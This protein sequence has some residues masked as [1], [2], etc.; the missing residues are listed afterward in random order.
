MSGFHPKKTYRL[1]SERIR[2]AV[3]FYLIP[4]KCYLS[5]KYKQIF[6]RPIDWKNP[7][8]FSEKLNWLKIY[9]RKPI[10]HLLVDKFRAKQIVADIIGEE[11]IIPTI[12]GPFQNVSE[13]DK[14]KLPERFVI[15]CNHDAASLMICEDK[16]KFDWKFADYKLTNCMNIDFYKSDCRQ[17]TYKGIERCIFV[18]QFIEDDKFDCLAD[19]KFYC[20]NG[21][22]KAIYVTINRFTKMS[23]SMYDMDWNLMPFEHIHP[24]RGDKVP[25]PKN[26]QLMKELAE[27][28]AK[29]V[30]NPYVRVDFYETNGRVYFGEITF[31]PESGMCYFKPEEWDYTMGSWMDISA[32]QKK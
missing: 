18:E 14:D 17:W 3:P 23:V 20:F 24:N 5:W 21:E 22:A 31:Y 12:A 28:V 19:Y 15:K 9:D 1:L 29:F 30:D 8:T 2:T 4:D 7:Q 16:S 10:Y 6:G 27:K 26:L 32:L 11:Y 13:I 25:K